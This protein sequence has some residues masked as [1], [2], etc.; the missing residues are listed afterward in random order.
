LVSW[1]GKPATLNFVSD[2]TERKRMEEQLKDYS[3]SLEKMVDMR[4]QELREA[5]EKLVRTEKLAAIGQLAGSISH[6]LRNPLGSIR[7]SAYFLKAKLGNTADDMVRNHL[8]MLDTQVGVCDKIITD[9][10]GLARLER[11]KVAETDINKIIQEQV[12]IIDKPNNVEI[13]TY[14]ADNLPGA[15]ADSGQVE[16][17]LSNLISNAIQAMPDGGKLIFST[18]QKEDFVEVKVTDT[19]DGITQENMGKIFEPLF[20]T[21]AKGVGLG[22]SI[23]R[24]L[25]EKHGGTIEVESQIEQGTTFTIRLP[26]IG[27]KENS[28]E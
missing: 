5:Q 23:S 13:S 14:L 18:N 7:A 9:I 11:P 6:E 26:I 3:E 16:R 19:G 27:R 2:L 10:L 8:A 12:K 28:N 21:K 22:L 25:I 4:T 24:A 17:V 1:R 20:T 15:M